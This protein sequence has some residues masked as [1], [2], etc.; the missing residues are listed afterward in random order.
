M[1]KEFFSERFDKNCSPLENI[2]K[3]SLIFYFASLVKLKISKQLAKISGDLLVKRNKKFT[4]CIE[5]K[6]NDF[7]KNQIF[8]SFCSAQ[9]NF[10]K[11]FKKMNILF[12]SL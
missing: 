1:K 3:E 6:K 8:N 2:Y 5:A 11:R 7:P 10:E 4:I 12:I 9:R